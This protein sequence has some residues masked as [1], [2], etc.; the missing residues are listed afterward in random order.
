MKKLAIVLGM[1]LVAAGAVFAQNDLQVLTV[2]NYNKSESIT[3]KQLKSRCEVYEKQNKRTLSINEKKTVLQALVEEKLV[4]QA[5]AKAGITIP[6][7]TID[8]YFLQTMS[9]QIGANVTEKELNDIVMKQEGITLDALLKKQVGMNVAEYKAFLKNQLIA[10]QYVVQQKENDIKKV[11]ATDE[12]IRNF[13]VGNKA[14]F[15]WSDMVKLF[16]VIVPRGNDPDSAKNKLTS[17]RNNY[18]NKSKKVNDFINESKK[19]TSGYQAGEI[20]IP[21]TEVAAMQIGMPYNNLVVLNK[22]NE[23]FVSD[24]QET[25]VD[26]RFLVIEKKYAAKMLEISDPVQPETNVTV[27]EFIKGN[28]TQQKQMLYVQQAAQE[29]TNSLNKPEYVSNKKTGADLDALLNW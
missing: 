10:Q 26:Y 15:V 14:T 23:G 3:V 17:L 1:M 21:V 6:D 20:I 4:L 7:S 25:P 13:Y 2:V 24:V 22:Q 8:Q 19:E 12:E 27:Y 11:A 9:A 5:A 28:L 18:V 29:I 16:M